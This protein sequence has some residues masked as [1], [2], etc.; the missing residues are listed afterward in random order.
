MQKTT[1][2]LMRDAV[3]HLIFKWAYLLLYTSDFANF[4]CWAQNKNSPFCPR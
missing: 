4:F 3:K 1:K 2:S